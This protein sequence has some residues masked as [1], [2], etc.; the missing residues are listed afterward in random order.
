MRTFLRCRRVCSGLDLAPTATTCYAWP[1]SGGTPLMPVPGSRS[2][3]VPCAFLAQDDEVFGLL[4]AS[5]SCRRTN[6]RP[7]RN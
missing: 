3:I 5:L 2:T 6:S 4:S 1:W 7:G